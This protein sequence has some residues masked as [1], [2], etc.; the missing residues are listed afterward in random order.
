MILAFT[1]FFTGLHDQKQ[2]LKY[3]FTAEIWTMT[4]SPEKN[5]TT[6]FLL[7]VRR[8]IYAFYLWTE[9]RFQ[10]INNRLGGQWFEVCCFNNIG[11]TTRRWCKH[12]FV[13]MFWKIKMANNN[14]VVPRNSRLHT[15]EIK[16]SLTSRAHW[17]PRV[18][19]DSG[20][21]GVCSRFNSCADSPSRRH[22]MYVVRYFSHLRVLS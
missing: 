18:T 4:V 3:V 8:S 11:E 2:I 22:L 5:R 7:F 6:A 17:R 1:L 10:T 20:G 13:D 9:N 14:I 19:K 12:L 21:G 15:K 16:Q